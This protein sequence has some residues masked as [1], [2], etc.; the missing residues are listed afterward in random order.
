MLTKEQIRQ[1]E[2]NKNLFLF[3]VE[4]LEEM[5]K[6]GEKEM[7]IIFNGGKV[8]RRKK[9]KYN[10]IKARVMKVNEPICR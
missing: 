5:N 4:L 1:I 10:W 8:I 6:K 2:N 9:N 3:I 7:T